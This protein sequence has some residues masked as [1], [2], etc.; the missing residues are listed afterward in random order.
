MMGSLVASTSETIFGS[1]IWNP[2]LYLDKLVSSHYTPA[3]RAGRFF[4]ALMFGFSCT[5]SCIFENILPAGNDMAALLPRYINIKRGFLICTLLSIACVPWKILGSGQNFLSWLSSY[6]TFLSAVVGVLLAQYYVVSR[7]VLH[8]YPD[9]YN[10]KNS[11][12]LCWHGISWRGFAAY[13]IGVIP[14]FYGFLGTVGVHI[15]RGG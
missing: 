1:I 11:I 3:Y 7:Q 4:L 12:Y 5:F 8:L 6:Q 9:L 2:L 13:I 15:T 14:N 10:S